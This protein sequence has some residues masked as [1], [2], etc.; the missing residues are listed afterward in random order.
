MTKKIGV[1]T[2]GSDSPGLNAAIRSVGKSLIGYYGMEF[3]GFLDGFKGLVE[4]HSIEIK[5]NDLSGI[6]SS[7]GTILGTSRSTPQEMH[8]GG[9]VLDMGDAAVKTYK[10]HKLDALVCLGGHSTMIGA[11]YL[12]Q[13]GLNIIALPKSIDNNVPKT[14]NT[15][16]FDTAIGIAAEAIDRLHSTA[17]SHHRIMIAEFMGKRT[18]WLTLGAG[19]AGGADVILIPEIPY[20]YEKITEAIMKRSES[21]KRFSIIAVSEGARSKDQVSF[22]ERSREANTRLRSGKQRTEIADE[23]TKIE[24]R[25]TGNTLLL[26]DQLE[27]STGLETRITIMGYLLRGGIP[28]ATDRLYATQLGTA[29]AELIK[30]GQYG[31]MV[32]LQ[33]YN[34]ISVP[35]EEVVGKDKPVPL[36]HPWI[37]SARRVGTALGD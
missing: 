18:G 29:C 17:H 2:S 37:L 11:H 26:A 33:G 10:K 34:T 6:L 36:D 8:I 23:L 4:D 5:S 15:V 7:G 30:K 20:D 21:G 13:K 19:I 14:D 25:M 32:A 16:G 35:I 24:N 12:M 3:I 22:I 28:S 1:L 27:K 9:E 31:V